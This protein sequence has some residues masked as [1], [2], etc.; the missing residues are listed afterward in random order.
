MT[1]LGTFIG[2]MGVTKRCIKR[3]RGCL[4]LRFCIVSVK[5]P[6]KLWGTCWSQ[7][8]NHLY[9]SLLELDPQYTETEHTGCISEG[10]AIDQ[11]HV[12]GAKPSWR[13]LGS[14]FQLAFTPF[15][16]FPCRER[17]HS[18]W[19]SEAVEV[20]QA[21]LPHL[22]CPFVLSLHFWKSCLDLALTELL[23]RPCHHRGKC[24]VMQPPD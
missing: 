6:G 1:G 13:N 22:S 2:I 21:L 23:S 7:W 18:L 12:Y 9:Q 4:C 5:H 10:P 16:L 3:K 14:L 15:Q 24:P 19:P 17:H 8:V 11:P 20:I